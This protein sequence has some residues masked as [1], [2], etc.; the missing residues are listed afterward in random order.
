MFHRRSSFDK[1]ILMA[2]QMDLPMKYVNCTTLKDMFNNGLRTLWLAAQLV[3]IF[4]SPPLGEPGV[5]WA[6]TNR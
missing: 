1:W 3:T 5:W 4:P 6:S 2:M